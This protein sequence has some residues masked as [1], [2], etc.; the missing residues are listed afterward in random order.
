LL[1]VL[2]CG[3][4]P[5]LVDDLTELFYHVRFWLDPKRTTA[6]VPRYRKRPACGN[7]YLTA[8][9]IKVTVLQLE[10]IIAF[11]SALLN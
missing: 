2:G 4:H 9:H 3:K 5:F 8:C 6:N 11:L 10:H 7:G 1:G